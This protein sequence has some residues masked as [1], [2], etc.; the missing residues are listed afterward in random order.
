MRE[1]GP[2]DVADVPKENKLDI[3][4]L[5]IL[6]FTN[7]M[8]VGPAHSA[9]GPPKVGCIGDMRGQ[10]VEVSEDAGQQVAV[11]LRYVLVDDDWLLELQPH[12]Q[13]CA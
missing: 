2:P 5:T 1:D 7:P 10:V 9:D 13:P 3:P 12:A 8:M 6:L 4:S 11:E